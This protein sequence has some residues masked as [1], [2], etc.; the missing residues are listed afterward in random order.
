VRDHFMH[1]LDI[2]R[3]IGRE[4]PVGDAERRV[5]HDAFR[6]W[7]NKT[8]A[9]VTLELTGPAGGTFVRGTGDT[10]IKG[11]AL[12]LCRVLAGRRGDGLEIEGDREAA[13]RWLGVL[14][15]F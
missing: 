3:A 6:E 11:D 12:D 1:H 9:S 8:K 14:A 2:C 13:T 10:R 4:V 5:A 7:G 15:A